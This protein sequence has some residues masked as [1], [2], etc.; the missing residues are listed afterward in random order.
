MSTKMSWIVS[1][2]EVGTGSYNLPTYF[3][4]TVATVRAS[5]VQGIL[6]GGR[7]E[8]AHQQLQ[9]AVLTAQKYRAVN[10]DYQ[11]IDVEELVDNGYVLPGF[12]DGDDENIFGLDL[13]I[14]PTTGGADA[15][16]DY[17]TD[18]SEACEQLE[19]RIAGSSYIS[20]APAC[21]AANKLEF[22]IH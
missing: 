17:E 12:D 22:T 14:T 18:S 1:I 16:F 19:S 3:F 7:V 2:K 6:D 10:G 11:N 5:T 9:N 15:E 13:V 21:D 8:Q 20:V 4:R